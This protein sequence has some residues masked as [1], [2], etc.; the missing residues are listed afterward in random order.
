MQSKTIRFAAVFCLAAALTQPA[1][2]G[3]KGGAVDELHTPAKGTPERQAIM[4]AVRDDYKKNNGVQVTFLVNYLKIHN[5]WCWTD[6]TPL[7]PDSKPVAE[8]GTLLLHYE[9]DR[10]NIID[11]SKVADDPDDP[12]A[13]QDASPGFIRNLRK[14]YPDVPTDIF[15]RKKGSK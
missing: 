15:P 8:G 9:Q 2:G 12:M 13:S 4:D 11:L 1:L 10:W 5:G 14:I 3:A 7:G 6:L